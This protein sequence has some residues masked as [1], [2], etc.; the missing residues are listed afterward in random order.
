L[1]ALADGTNGSNGIYQY[2][3]ASAFPTS[4]FGS[5]NYWVDLVFVDNVPPTISAVAASTTSTTATITWTTSEPANS[6]VAYGTVSNSLTLNASNAAMVTAQSITLTGLVSGTTYYYRVT[7]VDPSGNSSTSPV[8]ANAPLS[9]VPTTAPPVISAVT[10]TPAST[11][12][13]ITWTTDTNST[14]VVNYGTSPSSLTLNAS[15]ASLV[16]SHS[17]SLTGLTVGTTYYYQVTSVNASGGSSTSPSAPASFVTINS[18]PP[19]ISAVTAT[20]GIS[21]AAT[22]AWTTDQLSTS[23]VAYGTAPGSLTLNASNATLV[24]AHSLTLTGLTQGTTYYFTVTSANA[25]GFASTSPVTPAS[26]MENA[27]SLWAPATTPATIDSADPGAVE[28]GMKF[29]STTAGFISGVRF[30]K[31]AT[32]TGSHL[33]HLWSSTGTLLGTVT[34]TG[35]TAS[36]WQQANFATPISIAANT[37]Y[38]VSYYAPSGHY[39]VNGSYFATAATNAPLQGLANATSPNGVYIYGASAF[40]NQSFNSDNYWVDVLYHP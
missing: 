18:I 17:I 31:A 20:A 14:S 3:A 28:L 6:S 1:H 8:A 19:V 29:Q 2:S 40:P 27:I 39:S 35:E 30:Y 25:S 11:S 5:A 22:I 4:T 15:N 7:S 16:T 32:N 34:F 12:A 24:T 9:F 36:G 23:S 21:G 26:F 10:A 37:V 33:G 38:I 13:I